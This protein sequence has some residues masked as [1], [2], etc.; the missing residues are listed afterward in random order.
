MALTLDRKPY[1]AGYYAGLNK[2]SLDSCR[3][4]K[5]IKRNCWIRGYQDGKA[6]LD[7]R[8]AA[9][10]PQITSEDRTNSM[11]WVQNLR[12]KLKTQQ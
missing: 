4:S 11:Q 3:Y 1:I 5:V 9:Q 7:R 6:E 8:T 12:S 2:N 10:H